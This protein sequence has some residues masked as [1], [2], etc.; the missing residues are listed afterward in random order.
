MCVCCV[1]V[2]VLCVHVC[3]L[4]ACGLVGVWVGVVQCVVHLCVC[5]HT[6]PSLPHLSTSGGG[7]LA[8]TILGV[9]YDHVLGETHFLVLDP[10]YT[11]GEDMRTILNKGWCGWKGV[12]FWSKQVCVRV[13]GMCV[14]VACACVHAC[15]Y[16]SG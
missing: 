8:H 13:C 5:V 15:E 12:D 14:C 3:V 6:P 10:H 9:Q 7:V 2:C 11:G 4:C 1:Y 16:H